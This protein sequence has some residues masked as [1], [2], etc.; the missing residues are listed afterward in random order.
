MESDYEDLESQTSLNLIC[1]PQR[2]HSFGAKAENRAS[3]R[4]DRRQDT[5]SI[6]SWRAGARE[7]GWQ[8]VSTDKVDTSDK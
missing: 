1:R 5:G 6:A 4:P 2:G 8:A 3:G 7:A